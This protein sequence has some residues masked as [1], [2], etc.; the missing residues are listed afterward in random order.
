VARNLTADDL[1][2]FYGLCED[3]WWSAYELHSKVGDAR[4][5]RATPGRAHPLK[6]VAACSI[7]VNSGAD[8][9]R[10]FL[11]TWPEAAIHVALVRR[12]APLVQGA[13]KD[14]LFLQLV[15]RLAELQ[16]EAANTPC[17]GAVGYRSEA[18]PRPT[19][20]TNGTV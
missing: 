16:R 7:F 14:T 20:A 11:R 13:A 4:P 9:A 1:L 3:E 5:L 15:W 19:R 17:V 8:C 12:A 10:R 2:I 18:K 6:R